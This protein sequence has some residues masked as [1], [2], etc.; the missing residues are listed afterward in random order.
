MEDQFYMIGTD[1]RIRDSF[2][3]D[4]KPTQ[5]E[6]SRM[7]SLL[8]QIEESIEAVKILGHK[9]KSSRITCSVKRRMD[10]ETDRLTFI[11]ESLEE[12]V[13]KNNGLRDQFVFDINKLKRKIERISGEFSPFLDSFSKLYLVRTLNLHRIV[14]L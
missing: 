3:I 14:L 6:I 5:V 12:M 1:G 8:E 2:L 13:V 9:S 11:C 4:K 10:E 7:K